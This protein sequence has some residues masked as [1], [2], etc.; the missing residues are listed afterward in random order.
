MTDVSSIIQTARLGLRGNH[1]NQYDI[2][3]DNGRAKNLQTKANWW[4]SFG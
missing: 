4:I 1:T 2:G 3:S